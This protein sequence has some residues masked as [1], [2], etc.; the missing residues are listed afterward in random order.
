MCQRCVNEQRRDSRSFAQNQLVNSL[1]LQ[2]T[3]GIGDDLD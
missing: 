2:V 3:V 1:L